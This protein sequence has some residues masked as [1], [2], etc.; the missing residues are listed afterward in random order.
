[1]EPSIWPSEVATICTTLVAIANR[2]SFSIFRLLG[3]HWLGK[4]FG[5]A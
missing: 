5:D 1:M 2:K 4:L 3:Q